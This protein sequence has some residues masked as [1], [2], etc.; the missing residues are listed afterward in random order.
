LPS[1]G[2]H[3]RLHLEQVRGIQQYGGIQR[4]GYPAIHGFFPLPNPNSTAAR[5][6][7]EDGDSSRVSHIARGIALLPSSGPNLS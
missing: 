6:K 7:M 5:W 2:K 1:A 4:Y 3:C